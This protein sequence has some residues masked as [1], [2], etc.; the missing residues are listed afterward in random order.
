MKPTNTEH[1]PI[2]ANNTPIHVIVDIIMVLQYFH[3]KNS[4]NRQKRNERKYRADLQINV[5]R[6]FKVF[7]ICS[8]ERY[9]AIKEFIGR[10]IKK[11]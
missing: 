7:A 11:K 10:R 2:V 3:S 4:M 5:V 1:I 6:K 9:N 8:I